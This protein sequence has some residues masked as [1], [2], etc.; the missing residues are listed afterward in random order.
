MGDAI[1]R[2]A[3]PTGAMQIAVPSARYREPGKNTSHCK[4]LL[5]QFACIGELPYKSKRQTVGLRGGAFRCRARKNE[6]AADYP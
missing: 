6:N 1:G 2:F 3:T 4:E 5:A